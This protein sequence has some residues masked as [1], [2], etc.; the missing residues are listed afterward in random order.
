MATGSSQSLHFWSNFDPILPPKDGRNRKKQ[1]ILRKK[2]VH[3]AIQISQNQIPI[4]SQFPMKNTVTF[5]S[6]WFFQYKW[7]LGQRSRGQAAINVAINVG[8]LVVKKFS[9]SSFQSRVIPALVS[10]FTLSDPFFDFGPVLKCH[11]QK[12]EKNQLD[13]LMQ[14]FMGSI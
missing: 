3:Q 13:L 12:M 9:S 5:C 6:K 1:I 10:F 2:F 8:F 7:P 4:L 11:T 14:N